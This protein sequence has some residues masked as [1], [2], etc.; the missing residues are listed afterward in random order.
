MSV[1]GTGTSV[2][3]LLMMLRL[4]LAKV[5]SPWGES[6]ALLRDTTAWQVA[7]PGAAR[8]AAAL[9]ASRTTRAAALLVV[10]MFFGE[11]GYPEAWLTSLS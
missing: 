7:A 4:T 3:A 6:Q 1:Q 2:G 5:A 9:S 10:C 11:I 8:I